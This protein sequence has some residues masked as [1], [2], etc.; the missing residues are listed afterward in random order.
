MRI[1]DDAIH[2][3][4]LTKMQWRLGRTV[5]QEMLQRRIQTILM[6]QV[7]GEIPRPHCPPA[8]ETSIEFP[9]C[10]PSPDWT[11]KKDKDSDCVIGIRRA[12]VDKVNDHS[13]NSAIF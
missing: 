7:F 1:R 10:L 13:F 12:W 6:E 5:K 2:C 8:E 11:A 4:E 3:S 9:D